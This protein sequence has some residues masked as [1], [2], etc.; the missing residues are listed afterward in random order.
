MLPSDRSPAPTLV[1][2]MIPSQYDGLDFYCDYAI[3]NAAELDI[4]HDDDLVLAFHHTRPLWEHHVVVVP[5]RHV[6]SL[7]TVTSGDAP[8]MQRLLE[9]IQDVAQKMERQ[10]GAAAVLTNLGKYQDSKHLHVH[11]YSGARRISRH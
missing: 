1:G 10:H 2:V 7:T 11:V 5:K 9:V 4:V 3:P 8:D 6:S